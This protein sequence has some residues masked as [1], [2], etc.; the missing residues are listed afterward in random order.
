LGEASKNF[1][2]QIIFKKKSKLTMDT[3]LNKAQHK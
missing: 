1:R 3:S 2:W